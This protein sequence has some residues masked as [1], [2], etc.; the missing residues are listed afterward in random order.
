VGPD[1]CGS[2]FRGFRKS[3]DF[4]SER[5]GASLAVLPA[6]VLRGTHEYVP[7][8]PRRVLRRR[9]PLAN[10]GQHS[11]SV[12]LAGHR[13]DPGIRAFSRVSTTPRG[14]STHRCGGHSVARTATGSLHGCIHGVS[15]ASMGARAPMARDTPDC[16]AVIQSTDGF[17]TPSGAGRWYGR[18][19]TGVNRGFPAHYAHATMRR[20]HARKFPDVPIRYCFVR[21]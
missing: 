16:R 10:S 14:S 9:A 2:G 6:I 13:V 11:R 12:E 17:A 7:V 20:L 15:A 8:A 19:R 1:Q 18:I 21:L 3:H 5:P 4:A